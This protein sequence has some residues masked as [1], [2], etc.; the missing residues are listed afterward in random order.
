MFDGF[1]MNLLNKHTFE[2]D[3]T[4]WKNHID[5]KAGAFKNAVPKIV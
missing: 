1:N 3:Y 2:R 5:M 4:A